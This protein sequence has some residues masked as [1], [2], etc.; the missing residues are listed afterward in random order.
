MLDLG[1][2]PLYVVRRLVRFASEDIGNADPRALT[3]ALA[4]KDA[5]DFLGS[6]EGELAIAQATLFLALAPKS[7]AAYVAFNEAKADVQERAGRAGPAAHPQRAHRAHEGPRIRGLATS[8]R[9][10]RRTRRS[11]PEH[12]PEL[13]ARSAVL[14]AHGPRPRGRDGPPSGGL[15]AVARGP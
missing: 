10:M 15:A 2:E 5:Y 12:L 11:C 13:A 4:A 9:T 8:T 7:N 14:P 6:P 3:L 1:E